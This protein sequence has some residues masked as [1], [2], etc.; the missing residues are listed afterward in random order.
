MLARLRNEVL[1]PPTGVALVTGPTGSG[2]TTTLYSSLSYNNSKDIKIITAEDPVEYMIDG[3]V[4]CSVQEK[5][6]R[7]FESTLREIV[8]QDPDIIVLGEIRDH[9]TAVTAIQA[10]LTGHKVYST[11]HTEDTIG[12]LLRLLNMN[13]EPFLIASTLTGVVAQ[14][15][16]RRICE[17]C[18]A[19]YTPSG[20]E[21]DR[22][23]LKAA[24]LSNFDLMRG[25]GCSEC[26]YTGYYGRVGAYELLAPNDDVREA[27]LQ[28][29]SAHAIRKTCIES[30]GLISM[31][32]DA[33]AKVLRGKTTFEE[34]L[35]HTPASY[36]N[37]SLR[38][39]LSMTQ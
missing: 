18:A 11:F 23:G 21:L 33:I 12:A 8:R 30:T 16:L 25:R 14:R 10:A 22:L 32:E 13:I 29:Q 34:V 24:E 17:G 19:P 27:V 6:G 28:R 7:T 31:R 36:S 15:L 2:K 1:D 5:I 39:V 35:R 9:D 3:I 38:Q 26:S 20:V 37:R 4:Q